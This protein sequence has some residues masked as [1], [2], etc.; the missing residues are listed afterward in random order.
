MA[1]ISKIAFF[2]GLMALLFAGAVQNSGWLAHGP[3]AAPRAQI[4]A[5]PPAP[6]D[7]APP[8]AAQLS[9]ASFG[10]VE[11]EPDRNAQYRTDIEIDGTSLSAMVD[12]GATFVTLTAEDARRLNIEPPASAY[13]I[14]VQTANGTSKVAHVRLREI[15]VNDIAIR[16]VDALVAPPGALNITLLGMSFLKKLES[17]HVADGRFV[18]KQ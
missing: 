11:L 17:F 18:M 2:L 4:G 7:S 8:A 1:Q 12:T 6:N 10:V 5:A 3:P 9:H 16:D 13:N 14:P 15:R